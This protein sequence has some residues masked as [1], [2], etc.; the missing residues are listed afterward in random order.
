[1][2]KPDDEDN[3]EEVEEQEEEHKQPEQKME[4]FYRPLQKTEAWEFYLSTKDHP[5]YLLH[6][7][8]VPG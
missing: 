4:A 1:M 3:D 8:A 2:D 6:T 5:Y 7:Y